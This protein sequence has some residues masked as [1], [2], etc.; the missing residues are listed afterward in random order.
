M[1]GAGLELVVPASDDFLFTAPVVF[2]RIEHPRLAVLKY[3][4][5]IFIKG[6]LGEEVGNSVQGLSVAE[7]DVLF[8]ATDTGFTFG[9][10]AR[11]DV[12]AF[13]LAQP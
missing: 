6:T 1:I 2:P 5:G 12:L 4:D 9:K 3:K 13:R 11:T 8:V 10:N 7:G